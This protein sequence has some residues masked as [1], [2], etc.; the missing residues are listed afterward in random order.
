MSITVT[1]Q[2]INDNFPIVLIKVAEEEKYLREFLDGKLYMK[3]SGYFRKV[4]DDYRG[5]PFDGRK[6]INTKSITIAI[7]VPETSERIMFNEESGL[8]LNSLSFGF[9]GDDRV[10]I[11]CMT[12]ISPDI[13]EIVDETHFKI[14]D[15]YVEEISKFGKHFVIV[16]SNRIL[17]LLNEYNK[18]HNDLK[19]ICG[20]VEYFDIEENNNFKL[21]ELNCMAFYQNFFKKRDTYRFQNEWRIVLTGDNSL[22]PEGE[23]HVYID[24]GKIE[25]TAIL[26]VEVLKKLA[27][28]FEESPNNG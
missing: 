5:D 11:F 26:P 22:I 24:I 7:E 12:R 16:H 23:D 17:Y 15:S 1:E 20:D 19:F 18:T 14:K 2:L 9:R 8:K 28:S 27:F 21:D 13:L 10:P 25:E 6:P 3:A 4:E